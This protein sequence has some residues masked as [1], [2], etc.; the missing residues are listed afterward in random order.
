MTYIP[1]LADLPP[2][3]NTSSQQGYV[4]S[5]SD[6]QEIHAQNVSSQQAQPSL[7]NQMAQSAPVQFT[8]GAGNALRNTGAD[9]LGLLGQGGQAIHNALLPQ[10]LQTHID[11]TKG[12]FAP[13]S[14]GQGTYTAGIIPTNAYA[15]GNVAGNI[16][17]FMG[18]AKLAEGARAAA[19]ASQDLPSAVT[20]AAQWLNENA[21]GRLAGRTAG[22]AAYGAVTNPDN[23][24]MGAAEGAGASLLGD[25]LVK[26][27]PATLGAIFNTKNSQSQIGNLVLNHLQRTA[28]ALSPEDAAENVNTNFLDKNGKP[29]QSIDIGTVTNNPFLKSLYNQALKYVPGTGVSKNINAVNKQI[30]DKA[31]SDAQDQISNEKNPAPINAVNQQINNVKQQQQNIGQQVDQAPNFLNNLASNV[32][33]RSNITGEL[34][35]STTDVFNQNR[36][37]SK[38]LYAPINESNLRIDKLGIDNPFQN[39]SSAV[40]DLLANKENFTNLFGDDKDMGSK[41]GAELDKANSFAQNQGKYGVTLPE[42]VKRIQTLGQLEAAANGS[43]RRAEGRLL[44]NLGDALSDDVHNALN[45]SGNSD[46][47]TQLKN[48]NDN[49]RQNV[50]PFYSNPDIRKSVTSDYVSPGAKLTKALHDPNY[51]SILMQLPKEH[52]DAAL[53][54]LMTGGKGTSEGF[55][56]M[57]P[58][59]IANSYSNFNVDTAKAVKQ[60]NP[61]ANA[62]FEDLPN[63]ISQREQLNNMQQAL[64]KQSDQLKKQQQK[65][66]NNLQTKLSDLKSQ[67]YGQT[68]EHTPLGAKLL[69][70]GKGLGIGAG[71]LYGLGN[72]ALLAGA[73]PSAAVGR[74]IAKA[75]TNPELIKA[76]INRGR[77]P[78]STSSPLA[79]KLSRAVL[80]GNVPQGGQ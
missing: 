57:S 32:S 54:Q 43:G 76:Y 8:L 20:N 59:D 41:L 26:G 69:A 38:Q 23:R 12:F 66:I 61:E 16:A 77:L 13:T 9:V 47:S 75:L 6:I 72:P 14:A 50:I 80:M 73:I 60:Y 49:Y 1:S 65:N 35:N 28:T 11:F 40:N 34:K 51:Q 44:G 18:A 58:Q 78:T 7:V 4:P 64:S 22:S 79:G 70:A 48:A 15:A 52:Q 62:Y 45:S 31:I 53:F 37:N 46:L 71:A 67:K 27:V 30:N 74:T 68:G 25:T 33:D 2:P 55:S 19:A 3:P 63:K 10:S 29:I 21:F 17:P 5:L 36:K 39:Y 24:T 42:A 56:R